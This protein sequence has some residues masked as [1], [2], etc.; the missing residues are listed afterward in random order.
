MDKEP[1]RPTPPD[2]ALYSH[3]QQPQQPP[4]AAATGGGNGSTP[5]T[6]ARAGGSSSTSASAAPS[7]SPSVGLGSYRPLNVKDALS[8]LDSVKAQFNGRPEI[9]NDFLDI[10]KDF[11]TQR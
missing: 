5:A 3:S 6:N 10:M 9:Y 4:P 11:K 8:Y 2:R 1:R 7:P